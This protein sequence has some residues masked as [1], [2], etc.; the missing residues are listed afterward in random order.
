MAA[1]FLAIIDTVIEKVKR[2]LRLIL[3]YYCLVSLHCWTVFTRSRLCELETVRQRLQLIIILT[4]IS[5]FLKSVL[6]KKLFSLWGSLLGSENQPD[7]H[8]NHIHSAL[9]SVVVG[10]II[11]ELESLREALSDVLDADLPSVLRGLG[12]DGD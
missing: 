5:G 1:H 7:Y 6:Y 3:I 11:P 12:A 2:F 8:L 10:I 4:V 9:F